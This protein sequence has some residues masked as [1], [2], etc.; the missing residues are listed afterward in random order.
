MKRESTGNITTTAFVLAVDL[1][2]LCLQSLVK[3]GSLQRNIK[4]VCVHNSC[5][6]C[7]GNNARF[8]CMTTY[9][10]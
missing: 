6:D 7:S 2:S 5:N 8:V 9:S 1:L 10:A 3:S 4:D